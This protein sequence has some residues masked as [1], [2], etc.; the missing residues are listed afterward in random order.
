VAEEAKETLEEMRDQAIAEILAIFADSDPAR[1]LKHVAHAAFM[2]G[3]WAG[4]LVQSTDILALQERENAEVL[5][6]CQT[7]EPRS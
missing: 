4:R 3:A 6:R 7:R 5:A 1:I 2:R